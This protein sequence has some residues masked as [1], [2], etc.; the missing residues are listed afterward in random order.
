M[1]TEQDYSWLITNKSVTVSYEGISHT[2][3][4]DEKNCDGLIAAIKNKEWDEI[5]KILSPETAVANRSDGDMRVESGQ[6]W[7]KV[8]KGHRRDDGT[9]VDIEFAVPSGLNGTIIKY[10]DEGL[11]FRPLVKFAVKLSHNPSYRSVEQLFSFLEVNNFTITEEG[12][13]VAYK[14]IRKDFRDVHSGKFDNSIGQ[15]V[16]MPR[17]EVDDDPNRTCSR[18]LHVANYHY[19]HNIYA[20]PVTVFVEVDPKDVVAVPID[21]NNAKMRV[22]EYKVLGLS[23]GEIKDPIYNY[24]SDE[25]ADGEF[26]YEDQ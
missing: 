8:P 13:F 9:E 16:K 21:Y 24:V 4:R 17:D 5:P 25:D 22:C 2:I 23:E 11:P 20:G 7:V 1:R 26:D 18:G 19:A 10:I 12:N 3:L 14:S 15:T 6:V